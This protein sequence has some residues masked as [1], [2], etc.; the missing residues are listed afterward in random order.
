MLQT[1]KSRFVRRTRGARIVHLIPFAELSRITQ[2]LQLQYQTELAQSHVT[3]MKSPNHKHG[4]HD[5][6]K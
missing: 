4:N 2:V 5:R 3:L 6:Q 1:L